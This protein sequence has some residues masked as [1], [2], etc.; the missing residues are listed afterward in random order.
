MY[1]QS[2]VNS[3]TVSVLPVCHGQWLSVGEM[4]HNAS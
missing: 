1:L 4:W 3:F 2:A